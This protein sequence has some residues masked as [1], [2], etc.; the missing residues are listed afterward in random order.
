MKELKKMTDEQIIEYVRTKDEE[1]YSQIINRYQNKLIRY[2]NYL[3]N[4]NDDAAD[5]VQNSFIKAFINLNNFN[6]KK[7]FS[8]W[9]YRIVHNEAIN[10]IKKNKY[11]LPITDKMDFKSEEDIEMEFTKKEIQ[12][13][14]HNCLSQIPLL[15]SE[16]LTLFFIEEKSYSE[17]SDILRVPVNTVG[18]RIKRA[19]ILMKKICQ[20]K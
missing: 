8:S 16:P 11:E 5:I 12:A 18:T 17:I 6:I 13:M 9:I 4:D 14:I 3:I 7:K 15:Y 19:K 1:A 10:A 20:K 2:S